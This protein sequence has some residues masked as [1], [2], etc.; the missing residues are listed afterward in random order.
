MYDVYNRHESTPKNDIIV[1]V[2]YSPLH[3]ALICHQ[4]MMLPGLTHVFPSIKDQ[5][6]GI[7]LFY[8]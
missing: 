4:V 3:F 6:D 8:K 2:G 7:F 1:K 5:G